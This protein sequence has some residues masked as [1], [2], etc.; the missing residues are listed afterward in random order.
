[1]VFFLFIMAALVTSCMSQPPIDQEEPLPADQPVVEEPI[2]EEPAALQQEESTPDTE[3]EEQG[4]EV[5]FAV[6]EEVYTKTFDEVKAFVE[7][8]NKIIRNK[9][10]QLW[11]TYL[12]EEYREHTDD[13][14][15]LKEQSEKPIL[16]K[17]NIVLHSLEDYFYYVVVPSRSQA[18]LDDIEFIDENRLK[19]ISI[20]RNNRVLLYL[21][22]RVEGGWKIGLW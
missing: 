12:S 10:Y 4:S 11:L 3:P 20:I 5:N 2:A 7:N 14:V 8:L 19:A 13:V 1:M 9:N 16:K 18:K 22:I 15:N 6:T 21:L 17:N